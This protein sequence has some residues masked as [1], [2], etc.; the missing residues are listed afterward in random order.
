M[1]KRSSSIKCLLII[2]VHFLTGI[3]LHLVQL[4]LS[5]S[6][7]FSYSEVTIRFLFTIVIDALITTIVLLI[8]KQPVNDYGICHFSDITFYYYQYI[9]IFMLCLVT[10]MKNSRELSGLLF[11]TGNLV[12]VVAL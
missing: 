6:I 3:Y 8:S 9:F 2:L 10:G 12:Q 5:I 7:W 11:F 1:K 4:M